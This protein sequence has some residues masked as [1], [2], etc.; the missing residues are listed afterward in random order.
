MLKTT[1]IVMFATAVCAQFQDETTT[2]APE[3][4]LSLASLHTHTPG[5][6]LLNILLFVKCAQGARG[7]HPLSRYLR[8]PEQFCLTT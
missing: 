4:S 1:A 2:E 7:F 8:Y 6:Y 5:V 3:V